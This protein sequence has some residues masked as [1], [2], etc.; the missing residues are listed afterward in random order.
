M[1]SA[2]VVLG[3]CTCC[4]MPYLMTSCVRLSSLVLVGEL[5]GTPLRAQLLNIVSSLIKVMAIRINNHGAA[6]AE[7]LDI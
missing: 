3:Q 2:E 1:T 7:H 6:A 5:L 4:L